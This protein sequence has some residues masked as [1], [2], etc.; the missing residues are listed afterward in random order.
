MTTIHTYLHTLQ[1]YTIYTRRRVHN[2]EVE[3]FG[4]DSYIHTCN[5]DKQR[6]EEKKE[7]I[8]RE[9]TTL[10]YCVALAA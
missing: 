4:V 3:A 6:K 5:T 10:F 9:K 7:I 8:K 2:M 1:T